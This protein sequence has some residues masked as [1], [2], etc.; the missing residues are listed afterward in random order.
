M[1]KCHDGSAPEYISDNLDL[2][3]EVNIRESR[4]TDDTTYKI[5]GTRINITDT[6]LFVQGPTVWNKIPAHIREAD[7]VELFKK[8]YKKE[9]LGKK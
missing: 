8:Q 1:F 5:P 6:G 2:H 3:K 9:I 7:S 4:H